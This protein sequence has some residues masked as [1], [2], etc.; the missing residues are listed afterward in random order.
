LNLADSFNLAPLLPLID[1]DE[2]HVAVA[3]ARA[4]QAGGLPVM[5]VVLRRPR[6]LECLAA[7]AAD[8]NGV[9]VGAGTVLDAAQANAAL[10]R[11]AEFLVSPGLDDGVIA[12]ARDRHAFVLP[13]IMT[14]GE[15]QRAWNLGLDTVKFFP[16][17]IAGGVSAIRALAS[18]FPRVRF[19][20]TGGV[21]RVNLHEF[22]ALDCV[23]ACGGSWL[24]PA[25]AVKTGRFDRITALAAEAL[26]TAADARGASRSVNAAGDAAGTA[27][28]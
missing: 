17:A 28:A 9:I 25:D 23:L 27:N 14:P 15:L 12:A 10:E 20:P 13:G 22:L 3:V 18:V 8:L 21:S 16:A 1:V 7:V 4:L 5:E 2:P 26:T 6:A 19:V 11:G 24:T